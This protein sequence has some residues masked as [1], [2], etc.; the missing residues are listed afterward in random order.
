V[1]GLEINHSAPLQWS[2]LEPGLFHARLELTRLADEQ[3]V[4]IVALKIDPSKFSLL[5]LSAP[6]VTQEPAAW[7]KDMAEKT[8]A[9][10]AINASFY[11]PETYEPI[12]LL[13]AGGEVI[14]PWSA[15][16]GS[17]AFRIK[18]GRAYIEWAKEYKPVWERDDLLVQARPL[19]IEPNKRPGIYRDTGRYRAR[20][21]VGISKDR[22]V[23]LVCVLKTDSSGGQLS[24]LDLFELMLIMLHPERKGGLGLV[25]ALNLDGGTSTALY[26]NHPYLKLDINAAHQVANAIA[27]FR[28]GEAPDPAPL[29]RIP[30]DAYL[31]DQNQP[32]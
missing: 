11:L 1:G 30:E 17:G 31:Q 21:A 20:T 26:V 23:V 9:L 13:V 6:A 24:G 3:K 25:T 12:G 8:K 7:V 22:M 32:E 10:A 16:A 14:H 28:K 5:L 15:G 18:D 19:I 4:R 27:V 2:P 29:A